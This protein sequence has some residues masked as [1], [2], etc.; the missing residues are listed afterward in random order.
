MCE[1]HPDM[2]QFDEVSLERI[3]E[4]VLKSYEFG[5]LRAE[6]SV[7]LHFGDKFKVHLR[8]LFSTERTANKFASLRYTSVFVHFGGQDSILPP[9]NCSDIF[10]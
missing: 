5:Y 10:A 2:F 1:A 6:I 9:E 4:M 8:V 7:R 3:I